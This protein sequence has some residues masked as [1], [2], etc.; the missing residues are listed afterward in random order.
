[1]QSFVKIK[2]WRNGKFTVPFIDIGK[3]CLDRKFFTSLMCLS[4][5]FSKIKFSQKF[6][7][8]S[9]VESFEQYKEHGSIVDH[10]LFLALVA[11]LFSGVEQ[12]GQFW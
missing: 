1:M 10:F 6:L 11:I 9:I 5:L 7:T 2:H 8:V 12:F 3:S 4:M